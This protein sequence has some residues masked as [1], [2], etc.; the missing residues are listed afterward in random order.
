MLNWVE[1]EKSFITSGPGLF[2][3]FLVWYS[4]DQTFLNFLQVVKKKKICFLALGKKKIW[5]V[6]TADH[7]NLVVLMQAYKWPLQ[8]KWNS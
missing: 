3:E 1:H 6:F 7:T 2:Y 8:W 4:L 5:E